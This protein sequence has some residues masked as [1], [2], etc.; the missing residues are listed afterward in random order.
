M[1]LSFEQR[2]SAGGRALACGLFGGG[3]SSSTSIT[4]TQTINTDSRMVVDGGGVG[5]NS[6]GG[7][8]AVSNYATDGGL[9]NAGLAIAGGARDIAMTALNNN[10]FNTSALIAATTKL[11]EQGAQSL[12]LNTQL[13]GNI[14]SAGAASNTASFKSLLEA[15]MA[16]F[17]TNNAAAAENLD[18]TQH[19]ADSAASAYSDATAQATGNKQLLMVGLAVVGIVAAFALSKGKL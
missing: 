16:M 14:A 9:V 4:E 1:I 17:K 8:V 12:A 18:L 11:G 2:H 7:A 3:N 10:A 19:L 6:G 15:G 13:A 5:V